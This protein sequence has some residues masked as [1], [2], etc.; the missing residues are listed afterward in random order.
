MKGEQCVR[1]FLSTEINEYYYT[2]DLIKT[3]HDL[4]ENLTEC[5]L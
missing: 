5:P 2:K 1:G 3:Q 4:T